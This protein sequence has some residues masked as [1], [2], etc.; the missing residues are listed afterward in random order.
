MEMSSQ[1]L[2]IP[3]SKTHREPNSVL[4]FWS[5]SSWWGGFRPR[6]RICPSCLSQIPSMFSLFQ[7]D[8]AISLKSYH[9]RLPQFS[10][11]HSTNLE[12]VAFTIYPIVLTYKFQLH[13]FQSW[14]PIM[15]PHTLP[16]QHIT[17][18]KLLIHIYRPRQAPC[19]LSSMM[20]RILKSFSL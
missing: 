12:F 7:L 19:T 20:A 18:C 11:W 8:V 17:I 9:L 10:F 15:P 14:D 6:L 13:A 5:S 2:G 4:F 1:L 16:S 3:S